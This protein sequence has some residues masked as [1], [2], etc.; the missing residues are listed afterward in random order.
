MGRWKVVIAVAL[1]TVPASAVATPAATEAERLLDVAGNLECPDFD[2]D[3]LLIAPQEK[4]DAEAA[5][6]EKACLARLKAI[7]AAHDAPSATEQTRHEALKLY[8]NAV[9]DIG[10][11]HIETLKPATALQ[12]LEAGYAAMIEHEEGGKHFHTL[13]ENLPLMFETHRALALVGRDEDAAGALGNARQVIDGA[14]QSLGKGSANGQMIRDAL[15]AGYQLERNLGHFWAERSAD[16][17]T[18]GKADAAKAARAMAID[19]FSQWLRLSDSN[20]NESKHVSEER[21]ARS[22]GAEALHN[23]ARVQFAGGDRNAAAKSLAAAADRVCSMTNP[24]DD[25]REL[26][27]NLR[28]HQQIARGEIAGDFSPI[29]RIGAREQI[30]AM[31]AALMADVEANNQKVKQAMDSLS[32]GNK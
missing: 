32:A 17:A 7:K 26:C 24:L 1:A 6:V 27:T 22:V 3:L 13:I 14:Y 9:T 19:A 12:F 11:N 23:I 21:R 31:Q 28:K 2:R 8:L 18:A 10:R 15:R 30:A 16:L 5:R 20:F 4:I 29:G 25:D